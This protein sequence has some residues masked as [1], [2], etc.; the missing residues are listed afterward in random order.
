MSR[1]Y[2]EL[3][4]LAA[5]SS[6]QADGSART[7]FVAACKAFVHD[8]L[9]DG[10][11]PEEIIPYLHADLDA[12]AAQPGTE[13]KAVTLVREALLAQFDI[14]ARKNAARRRLIAAIPV[15][16]VALVVIG[17]FSWRFANLITID[18]P[19][20]T[21]EGLKQRAAAVEKVIRYDG[22]HL[23]DVKR[24][25]WFINLLAWPTEPTE[26]EIKGAGEFMG[27]VRTVSTNLVEQGPQG[28][29]YYCGISF[30]GNPLGMSMAMGNIARRIRSPGTEWRDPPLATLREAVRAFK[31]PDYAA[32]N[33]A[34]SKAR[35]QK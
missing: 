30:D 24:F 13:P 3:L 23:E 26:S 7:R 15:V 21:R 35:S 11:D 29:T 22:Y 32:I 20:D 18:Q 17:Y 12:L 25:R 5:R 8:L 4:D 14:R 10:G 28:Q 34:I 31:C 1:D 16:L 33:D 9:R 2:N 27:A 6:G 19:V